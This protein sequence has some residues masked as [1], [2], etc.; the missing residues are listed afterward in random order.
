MPSAL[1]KSGASVAA[2]SS[3]ARSVRAPLTI[4]GSVS[5]SSRAPSS[6]SFIDSVPVVSS[7]A[8]GSARTAATGPVSSPASIRMI[9]TPVSLSPRMMAH[10]IGA[11]PRSWGSNDAWT[12]K[13]PSGGRS[14]S[15]C[16]K[17]RPYATT[18]NRSAPK[19]ASAACVSVLRSFS[20]CSTRTPSASASR[21]TAG[22]VGA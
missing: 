9:D 20:G 8:I 5:T 10:W 3:C 18:T 2:P 15:A 6:A 13:G 21:L 22:A 16:G 7:S 11:A 4:P 19:A 12:L 17:I 1:V 14:S